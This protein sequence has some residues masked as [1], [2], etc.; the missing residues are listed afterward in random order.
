MTDK[1][2][3]MKRQ[4]IL[5]Y[6]SQTESSAF[7][8]LSFTRKN[9]LFGDYSN[10]KNTGQIQYSVDNGYFII[11]INKPR[12]AVK[13]IST[14]T[15]L[16]GYSYKKPFA[17]MPKIFMISNHNEVKLFDGSKKVRAEEAKVNLSG[18]TLTLSVPLKVL[19]EPDFLFVSVKVSEVS[20]PIYF[21]GFRKITV[22][23]RDNGG[24]KVNQ[25]K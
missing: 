24:T 7:Y 4:A 13:Y 8:L 1:Q 6:R 3:E 12:E 22:R 10:D 21:S 17:A 23:G 15:Y 9:E 19:G 25:D 2:L 20:S 16:F 14:L 18:E 11:R 5:S